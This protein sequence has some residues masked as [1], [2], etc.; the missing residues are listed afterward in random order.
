M[1]S[2][3]SSAS[4]FNNQPVDRKKKCCQKARFFIK[5]IASNGK[6]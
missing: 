3:G 4:C 5:E 1:I 6:D 2:C